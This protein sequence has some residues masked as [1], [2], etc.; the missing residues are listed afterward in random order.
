L[1]Q[2]EKEAGWKENIVFTAL[3]LVLSGFS[4]SMASKKTH[5]S[6]E[7]INKA[8]RDKEMVDRAR[9]IYNEKVKG[10]T[11]SSLYFNLKDSP[12]SSV[13]LDEIVK[14]IIEHE[15][16][17]PGQTPF[18]Y[19]SQE[20]KEWNDIN[21]FAI[22]KT[23]PKPLNRQNFIFLKNPQDVPKAVKAQLIKYIKNP[24]K[25]NLKSDPTIKQIIEK[26]DQTGAQDKIKYLLARLPDLDIN[27]PFSRYI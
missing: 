16:L 24:S 20:M 4:V 6:E 3:F 22:D 14:V 26:F 21:G 19:T 13:N 23:S 7:E 18:R 1:A 15:G 8:M 10:P 5:V 27:A 9:R 12:A 17:I 11:P 2:L 25:Y